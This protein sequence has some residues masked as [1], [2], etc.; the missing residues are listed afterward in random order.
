MSVLPGGAGAVRHQADLLLKSTSQNN[1][2]S[3]HHQCLR[4]FINSSGP[5][6]THPNHPRRIWTIIKSF[7]EQYS[8][9]FIVTTTKAICSVDISM[10]HPS[11]ATI[12][13]GVIHQRQPGR[14]IDRYARCSRFHIAMYSF[15]SSVRQ[16][17]TLAIDARIFVNSFY[18][19][20]CFYTT[21]L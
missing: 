6:L 19:G 1:A 9:S 10:A 18:F 5:S 17:V 12:H 11:A 7:T 8:R 16:R 3:D 15:S 20:S 4:T 2:H 13:G 21:S 14:N